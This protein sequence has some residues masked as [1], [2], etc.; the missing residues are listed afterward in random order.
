MTKRKS[1]IDIV[2]T[3]LAILAYLA[4]PFYLLFLF[5]IWGFGGMGGQTCG[6]PEILLIG[7][8]AVLLLIFIIPGLRNTLK[9]FLRGGMSPEERNRYLQQWLVVLIMYSAFLSG[10]YH[11]EHK[12]FLHELFTNYIKDSV[13]PTVKILK[14]RA[15]H[16]LGFQV[17]M[18]LQT[19]AGTFQQLLTGYTPSAAEECRDYF[20]TIPDTQCYVKEKP[21]R[22][23]Q[24]FL[25]WSASDNR[26]YFHAWGG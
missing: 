10:W 6:L 23:A 11:Y 15:V 3:L 7:L 4:T 14:G 20:P 16:W 26:A 9:L 2:F 21:Q 17:D 13:P 8:T 12:R 1:A 25:L 19:D 24:Y 22:N 18:T 5:Y